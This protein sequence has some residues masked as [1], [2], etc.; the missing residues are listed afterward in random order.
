MSHHDVTIREGVG[1]GLRFRAGHNPDYAAGI[2][3]RPVQEALA[4]HL[5]P[6]DVFYDIGANIGF[7]TV[8]GARLVAAEGH[9]VAF[10]PVPENAD[11]VRRNCELNSFGHVRVLQTAV[12][13]SVGTAALQV[14]HHA[15]GA[16]LADVALP[17]D[18]K[19]T[20]TVPTTTVDTL[21]AQQQVP[22]PSL[23]KID[24]EGAELNVL[25]GMRDTLRRFGPTIIYELDDGDAQ[26]LSRKTAACEQVLRDMDYDIQQLE[27]SYPDIEWLV[28]HFVARPRHKL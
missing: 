25:L 20:I 16:A 27:N 12:S 8:I 19:G 1:S 11:A 24:V 6:G 3:E 5:R 17:V 7:L 28:T 9:V 26:S 23:V 22:P 18:R 21:I 4:R 10:E 14:A 13:N 2:D 15:G